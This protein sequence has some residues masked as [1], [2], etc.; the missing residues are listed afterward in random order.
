[1]ARSFDFEDDDDDRVPA[2]KP[3]RR[4][5]TSRGFSLAFGGVFGCL[6]AVLVL[7]AVGVGGC[8]MLVN[9][10]NRDVAAKKMQRA[11]KGGGDDSTPE[12]GGTS[13]KPNAPVQFQDVTVTIKEIILDK[14]PLRDI[15]NQKTTS[16]DK[17]VRIVLTIRNNSQTKKIDYSS[18]RGNFRSDSTFKDNLGNTYKGIEFGITAI[19]GAVS[20]SASIHPGDTITD[21]IVFERPVDKATSFTLEL[22]GENVGAKTDLKLTLNKADFGDFASKP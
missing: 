14:V 15:M 17:A 8:V 1:M 12:S 11:A 2:K 19:V 20:S 13:V 7:G 18:W 3:R 21:I 16:T 10:I 4:T 5:E 22:K 9:S 6:L